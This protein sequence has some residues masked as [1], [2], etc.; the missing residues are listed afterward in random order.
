MASQL[1]VDLYGYDQKL[2]NINDIVRIANETVEA[3]GASVISE[4]YHEFS[5]IGISY[6]AVISTSHFSIHTWP[7]H[8][9]MA[10][11]IFSCY[12][13]L[14]EHMADELATRCRAKKVV[15]RHVERDIEG[16]GEACVS[17]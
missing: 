16:K 4:T 2:N 12:D 14:P 3:M 8:E 11:D 6:I 10:V 1:L 5:P 17:M 15:C 9:Y 13:D 7:E